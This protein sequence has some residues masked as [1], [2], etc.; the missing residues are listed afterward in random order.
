MMGEVIQSWKDQKLS[1]S[2]LKVLVPERRLLHEGPQPSGTESGLFMHKRLSIGLVCA[3]D[4]DR[5]VKPNK[6]V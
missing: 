4:K 6:R 1:I 2:A 3:W 5:H